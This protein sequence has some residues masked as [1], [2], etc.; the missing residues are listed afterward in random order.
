MEV[1]AHRL[2]AK[3]SSFSERVCPRNLTLG[4]TRSLTVSQKSTI[5]MLCRQV[6]STRVNG[7]YTQVNECL[8]P[9][10]STHGQVPAHVV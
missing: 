9:G 6:S 4:I 2:S 7:F 5:S 3:G 1:Q 8:E 10:M